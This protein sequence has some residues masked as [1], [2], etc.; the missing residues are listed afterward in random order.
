ME[1]VVG[2]IPTR[3]TKYLNNLD[4]GKRS[5]LEGLCHNPPFRC[6][7]RVYLEKYPVFERTLSPSCLGRMTILRKESSLM[8]LLG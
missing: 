5:Q 1:E 3:S 7:Q 4:W 6:S 2:S 8:G